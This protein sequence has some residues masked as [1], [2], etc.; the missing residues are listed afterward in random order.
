MGRV[1]G[2]VV[3]LTGAAR[4]QGAAEAEALALEGASV[5]ATDVLDG[6]ELATRLGIDYLHLDVRSPEQWQEVA[7]FARERFGRVDALVNNAG[8]P[9]RERLPNVTLEA[10]QRTFDVNVTGPMLGIQALLPLMR[11]GSTIVNV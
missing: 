6:A 4:G 7:R 1:S 2:K 10:W 9:A 5:I 8:I 11:P 3:V